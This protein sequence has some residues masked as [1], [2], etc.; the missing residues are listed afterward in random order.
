MD[1]RTG[2]SALANLPPNL[3]ISVGNFD[4]V[5]RGHE[6]IFELA[7]SLGAAG[8][9]CVTFEPHPLTVLRPEMAPPRLTPIDVK[10]Q[11]LAAA[12]VD[13][14]VE[15]PPTHDVLD[16]TAERFWEIL[17]DGTRPSHMIEGES[18]N[19]GKGRG[20]TIERLR[21]WSAGTA[22]KL[23]VIDPVQIA[24]MDLQVVPISSSLIRWLVAAGRV[25]DAAICLGRPYSLRGPV[26]EGF[27]RGRT[28]GV[29][30]ANLRI[31]EQLIPAEGVYAGRCSVAGVTYPAAV[32]IGTM[33]TFGDN[34]PQIEAHLVGFNGDLYGQTIDLELV[35]WIRD[36]R[37]FAGVDALKAQLQQDIAM[38]AELAKVR[39][40]EP[41]ALT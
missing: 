22:V 18:F 15:L 2:L 14:L 36:Q 25:R 8:L 7:R 21:E 19:F 11:L 33:P 1:V 24:L 12:G 34:P 30:T 17:R 20:G 5:H 13:Y 28:I 35:D 38:S 27:R 37:K 10:H 3:A 39:N 40:S 6:R 9:A 23:H 32:S 31:T 4:G 41:I 26:V 16:V 29:P